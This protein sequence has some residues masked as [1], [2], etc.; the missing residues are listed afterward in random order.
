MIEIKH[1][2]ASKVCRPLPQTLISIIIQIIL[3]ENPGFTAI[4]AYRPLQGF[5]YLN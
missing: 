1:L 4:N 3:S 5:N 2:I